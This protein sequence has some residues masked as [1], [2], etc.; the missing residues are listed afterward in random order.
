MKTSVLPADICRRRGIKLAPIITKCFDE[1]ASSREFPQAIQIH[2][3]TSTDAAHNQS[4]VD[5]GPEYE[6]ISRWS[7]TSQESSSVYSETVSGTGFSDHE[8]Y[9]QQ[10][11]RYRQFFDNRPLMRCLDN[12]GD[13]LLAE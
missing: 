5:L 10:L 9:E 2:M 12:E 8:S 4:I 11:H 7:S 1:T 3:T 13:Q 6:E